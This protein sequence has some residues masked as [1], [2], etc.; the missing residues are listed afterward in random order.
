MVAPRRITTDATFRY[1][2]R[3]RGV[4]RDGRLTRVMARTGPTTIVEQAR[5]VCQRGSRRHP[6]Y[7]L[8]TRRLAP[9]WLVVVARRLVPHPPYGDWD[10]C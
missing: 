1:S 5:G 3:A 7:S 2:L 6:I 10:S 8:H 4:I 9:G